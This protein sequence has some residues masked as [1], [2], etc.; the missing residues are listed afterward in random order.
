MPYIAISSGAVVFKAQRKDAELGCSGAPH[1]DSLGC[2][3][4]GRKGVEVQL[5]FFNEG[6]SRNDLGVRMEW[7]HQTSNSSGV[8][9][10][11]T[12]V[13]VARVYT[14]ADQ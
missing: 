10:E 6:S 3:L 4:R 11:I 7:P 12:E 5:L 1:D 8:F 14:I 2:F 9:L 13:S